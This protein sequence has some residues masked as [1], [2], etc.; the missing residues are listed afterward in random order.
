VANEIT[1]IPIFEKLY[2]AK[3]KRSPKELM[4]R[5]D[6]GIAELRDSD[7]PER[8]GIR[9]KGNLRRFYSYEISRGHRILYRVERTDDIVYV[10]LYRVCDHKNVYGND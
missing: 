8:I 3:K 9:K 4:K 1:V 5:V 6:D 2:T 7:E 10:H